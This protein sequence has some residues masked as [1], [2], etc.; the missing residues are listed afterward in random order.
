VPDT[1]TALRTCPLCEATCGLEVTVRDREVLSVRGDRADVFSHGYICPKAVGV[2]AIER[3]PDRVRTPLVRRDGRL[4][5]AS[6]DEAFEEVA[7][8]IDA[9]IAEHGRQALAI[10]LGNPNA[11]G[12]AGAFHLS[13]MVRAGG[14]RNVFSAST[15]DQM[16]K[17]VSSGLMFGAPLSIPVPDVDRTDHLMVLGANPL[18]SNG[19]LMTAPDMRGRLRALRAR[20]GRL[21]VVDPRRSRTAEEADEHVPIRPG[22][23]AHL[24][25][26]MASTLF[27]EG[28]VAP[29]RL[30]PLLGGVE[31]VRDALAPFTPEAVAPVCRVDAGTIR[32]LARELAAAPRAAV[33]GRIGTCTQEFG[34]LASWLVDVLNALTGNLDREGGA[35][36]TT[37]AAGARNTVGVP[38]HGR[39]FAT[40]RWR[41]RV[42][43]LPEVLGELPVACL[44][45]EIDTPGEGQV[46]ALITCAGNPVLSAPNAGRLERALS[47]LDFMV[48]VDLYVNET[49]RHAGVV[50]PAP[51]PLSRSHYDVLLLQLAVRNIA[52]Y[53]PPVLPLEPGAPDEW[54]ILLR[55]AGILGGQG[56]AAPL[57][58]LD[59]A[60]AAQ[61]VE[62][63]VALRGS[64]V[65]GRD[66]AAL[67]AMLGSWRGPER[68]LDLHLRVGPYGD[69]FGDEPDGLTL[70]RLAAHTHGL[71]LGPLQPRLPGVLR[72]VSGT[73][74]LAPAPLLADL[75]RLRDSL[76]RLAG[77]LVL[78]GRRQ[79]RSNNSWLHNVEVLVRGP[80]RCTLQ[81]HPD[82]AR[83]RALADGG[84]AR[85]S[86]RVGSVEIGVEVTDAI[87]PG[88]V[89]IPHGWGHQDTPN[90]VA[91]THAG[92]N[93]NL[94][95]DEQLVDPLSGN[96]VLNG[97]P[98][99]VEAL[100]PPV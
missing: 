88:V 7:R 81:M 21:V 23:D 89:S 79:L 10:Y 44:A 31:A 82:D 54:E 18:E 51:A 53:S 75:E 86:S 90:R 28:L 100:P 58:A 45:E 22:T 25:A 50:L 32:R 38:G 56:V 33:Y 99:T 30:A 8:R 9:V 78:V 49:T 34:T 5:P 6:W 12:I 46:R 26:A 2:A 67:L 97:V 66:P 94:L 91:A 41:S 40:G 55:L 57:Q 71:D 83:E 37:A 61:E 95:A 14:T 70:E 24:L 39:G 77:G 29:G 87:M 3:D 16:P 96:A 17:H 62:R 85:V 15:L 65:E 98:V 69:A 4:E 43:G 73:V 52:H 42:R 76:A 1:R 59:D 35:M 74:E 64:R 60:V 27:A 47:G 80:E 11:H 63:A 20:G 84:R 13:H 36:F 48:S 72:T 68:L 19:S 92:V 93:T